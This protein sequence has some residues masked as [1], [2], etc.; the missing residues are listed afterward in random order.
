[1]N[2]AV[3]G[4]QGFILGLLELRHEGLLYEQLL[5]G[6]IGRHEFQ[7]AWV[8]FEEV[9]GVECHMRSNR[10]IIVRVCCRKCD[11][12]EVDIMRLRSSPWRTP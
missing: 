8:S 10:T 1:M 3:L 9:E 7:H 12:N 5:Q 11:K 6:T 2:G 4:L